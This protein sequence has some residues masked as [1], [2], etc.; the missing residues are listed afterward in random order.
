MTF[1]SQ[2]VV[3]AG[4]YT[5]QQAPNIERSGIQLEIEALQGALAD[6]GLHI[7]DVDGVATTRR[8]STVPGSY[9][10]LYFWAE[11]LGQRPLS[12][13]GSAATGGLAA[14]AIGRAAL[15]VASGTCSVCVLVHG[16]SGS[17]INPSK[18]P[19][20]TNTPR[21]GD[22]SEAIFGATRVG[23]YAAWARRY[24]HEFGVTGEQL[25]KV[26][27]DTRYHATLNPAS[28]MGRRGEITVDDVMSSRVVASPFHLLDCALDNDGGY[29]I[30]ITTAERARDMKKPPV[31]ILGAG[32]AAYVDYYLN[33]PY[34]LFPPEGGAVKR[35]ADVAFKMAGIKR[36]ELDDAGLYDCFTVTVLRDLEEM[37]FCKLGEA[38]A[39]VQDGHTRLGGSMPVN[40]DGGLLSNSHSF[41]PGGMHVIEVVRQLR[42]EVEAARQ[43]PNAKIGVALSQGM[44]VHGAAGVIVLGGD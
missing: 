14:G 9:D 35:A 15:A 4:V 29:G 26:A 11:Q 28:I 22:W 30:V 17:K 40:T 27:V 13:L 23:W 10:P 6:A 41:N 39:F 7:R 21:V 32:E 44:S 19:L 20:P 33:L 34:P 25:A 1:S 37:G 38:A 31:F 2:Q 43:V 18:A 3:I 16:K 5:T 8:E 36:H 42:G 24:M 12:Y